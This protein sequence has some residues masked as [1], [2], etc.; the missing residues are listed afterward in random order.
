MSDF[1][2]LDF[3]T[4]DQGRDSACSLALVMVQGGRVRETWHHLIRP[5]RPRVMYTHIHG[6]TWDM[7]A[8][9][10]DFGYLWPEIR[11][12]VENAP[13]LVAHNAP[14]DKGVLTECCRAYGFAAPLSPFVCTVRVAR[15]TWNLRPTKLPDVCRFLAQPLKHHDALSDALACAEILLAAMRDGYDPS[16]QIPQPY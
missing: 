12:R 11:D 3:E 16:R 9:Q 8:D 7:V 5:P 15:D 4:A 10:P 2:A 1:I 14:F 6:I 13:F